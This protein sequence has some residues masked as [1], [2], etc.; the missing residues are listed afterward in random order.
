MFGAV[1]KYYAIRCAFSR[2]SLRTFIKAGVKGIEILFVESVSSKSQTLA[3]AL[4][5]Y[6]LS[7]TQEFDCVTYI[8]V[9]NKSENVVVGGTGFLFRS[10]VFVE[11]RYYVAL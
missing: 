9:V 10:K 6:N 7:C 2:F 1:L 4:I 8:R 11:I 3:E 5:V